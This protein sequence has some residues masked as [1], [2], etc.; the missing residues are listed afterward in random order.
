MGSFFGF[1][2]LR[3]GGNDCYRNFVVIGLVFLEWLVF[4][5]DFLVFDL[6]FKLDKCL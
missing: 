4:C 1:E 6:F 5:R 2:I 3:L